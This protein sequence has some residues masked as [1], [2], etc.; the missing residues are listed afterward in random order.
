MANDLI[1]EEEPLHTDQMQDIIGTPPLWL[2]RW[3]ISIVLAIVLICT[4]ISSVISYPEA[5]QT[6]IKIHSINSPY[7]L[8]LKDSALLIKLMVQNNNIV[9][10]G[11]SL[12]IL[13]NLMGKKILKAPKNGRVIYA[14]VI[15]EN[16]LLFPNQNIFFISDENKGFYGEMFVPQNGIYKVKSGQTVLIKLRNAVDERP[17][18]KGVVRYI[19]N[20]QLANST[21]VAE[22]EFYNLN[23]QAGNLLLRNGMIA[24][25]EIITANVTLL[26]RLINSLTKGIR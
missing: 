16:E 26:H 5:I 15:H 9:K 22:V 18:L 21:R 24:D 11:D 10:K 6:Q 4:L 14:G 19:T 23:N 12:A 13:E 3:G 17:I 1:Q 8:S 25:A 20:D 2:Y 7:G